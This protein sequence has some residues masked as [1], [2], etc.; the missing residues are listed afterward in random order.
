MNEELKYAIFGDV[1]GIGNNLANVAASNPFVLD[2]V[3]GIL[4]LDFS[5]QDSMSGYFQF[6]IIVYD[7][8]KIN[9]YLITI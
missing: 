8:G 7:N 9:K 1:V 6:Q 2:A 4:G 5:V 3:T